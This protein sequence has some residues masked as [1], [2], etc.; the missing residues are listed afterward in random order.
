MKKKFNKNKLELKEYKSKYKKAFKKLSLEWLNKYGLYED[1]DNK[2][3]NDPENYILNKGGKIYFALYEESIIGTFALIPSKNNVF[4][5]AKFAITTKYQG[6]G[7]AN[8]LLKK[9]IEVAK[10]KNAN[11]IIL[12]SNSK[13]KKAYNLYKKFNFKEVNLDKSKYETA[14]L[15]MKLKL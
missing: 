15:K 13:L 11:K 7:I 2:I 8:I 1:E 4:E 10:E 6:L 12:Y 9:A 5:L 3:L 14:D